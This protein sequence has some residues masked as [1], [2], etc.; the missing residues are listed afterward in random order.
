MTSFENRE[1]GK[2]R[3][4]VLKYLSDLLGDREEYVSYGKIAKAIGKSR[5]A[6]AYA[7]ER[8]RAEGKLRIFDGKLSVVA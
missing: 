1:K 3:M 2:T 7:V 6:V 8:L 4:D 5:H